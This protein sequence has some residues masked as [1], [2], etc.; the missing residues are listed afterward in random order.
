M[1]FLRFLCN[2]RV[3][4]ELFMTWGTVFTL[5]FEIGFPFLVWVRRLRWLML[6]GA[7]MLHMGIALFMGL[8]SFSAAMVI[9]VAVFVPPETVRGL[10]W[11]LGRGL[12]SARAGMRLNF[13]GRERRQVRI[14]C[15]VHAC[16]VWNQV[17]VVDAAAAR[18]GPAEGGPV[19]G[20]STAV[21]AVPGRPSSE[22]RQL[23]L[24]TNTAHVLTGYS[25]FQQLARSLPLLW[26]VALVTYIPGVAQ[27]GSS[28]YPGDS[29]APAPRLGE[30]G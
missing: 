9:A 2:H 25:L 29:L 16:D 4:W 19:P 24:I 6:V 3:W 10:V 18:R 14:A 30:I 11:A 5:A 15:L 1:D 7:V 20:G 17:E 13:N 12:V 21:S 28:L 22:T 26:P 23:Q 8:V 27:L